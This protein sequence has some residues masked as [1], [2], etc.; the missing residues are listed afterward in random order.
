M[1]GVIEVERQGLLQGHVQF[2][3]DGEGCDLIVEVV[4]HDDL[5]QLDQ[6]G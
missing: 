6:P 3:G 1:V 4:G 5:N 2:G